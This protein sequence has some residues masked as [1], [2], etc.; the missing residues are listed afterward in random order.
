MKRQIFALILLSTA[1]S[2]FAQQPGG[3]GGG[4]G[5][6]PQ[7]PPLFFKET[8]KEAPGNVPVTQDIVTNPNL[9]LSLYP[10]TNKEDF[11]I[12]SEG[13]VPHIWTGLCA[14]ACAL[15]LSDKNSFV[16]LTGKAKIRWYTKTSGFHEV[17]PILKLADG[18]WLIGNHVD[19][20]TFDYHEGE[21]YLSEVR[22]LKLD[23]A[24]VQT[25]GDLLDKVDL[26]KVD[27]IGFADLTPGSGHGSGGYSDVAWIEVY[28]KPVKRDAAS[29]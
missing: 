19:A 17:R 16:D 21:F 22:W 20:N 24:K 11:G 3:R 14:S 7:P 5:A 13:N 25:K 15:T 18:T 4:R 23:I 6:A 9:V 2:V 29:N 10:G 26:S 8:W 27:A 1:T 12:T 28:G